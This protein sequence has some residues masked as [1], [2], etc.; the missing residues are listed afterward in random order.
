[1]ARKPRRAPRRAPKKPVD[2]FDDY[3]TWDIRVSKTFFWSLILSVLVFIAGIWVAIVSILIQEDLLKQ[4]AG[5]EPSGVFMLIF[6]IIF[7]HLFIAVLFYILFRGG[8]LKLLKVLFKDRLVA[9]KYEDYQSLRILIAFLLLSAY[10]FI[11]SLL[12]FI[13]PGTVGKALADAMF[14]WM[15]TNLIFAIGIFM[16]IAIVVV[17]FCFVLW[18]HGV[19]WVLKRVKR[20]EEERE[21]KEKIAVEKLEKSDDEGLYEAYNKETGKKALYRNQET[22]GFLEWKEK[23]GL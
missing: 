5:W 7:V 8:K 6:G 1:M 12:F 23:K 3:S 4:I 9:K 19:Y 18:N 17:F 2:P 11:I 22:K 10:I 13:L 15:A 14:T 16:F 21:I 20:I